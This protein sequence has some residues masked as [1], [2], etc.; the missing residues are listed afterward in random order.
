MSAKSISSG[1]GSSVEDTR[2]V[3]SIGGTSVEKPPRFNS[4]ERTYRAKQQKFGMFETQNKRMASA[5][6]SRSKLLSNQNTDVQSSAKLNSRNMATVQVS[7]NL[8]MDEL[9]N[10]DNERFKK[11]VNQLYEGEKARNII[12]TRTNE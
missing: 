10:T 7:P 11:T 1:R 12:L 6:N 3:T 8:I 5:E 9:E 2:K 4:N